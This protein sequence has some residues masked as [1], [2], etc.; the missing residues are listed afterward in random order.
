MDLDRIRGDIHHISFV[1]DIFRAGAQPFVPP[2]AYGIGPA[3]GD[4]L[5]CPHQR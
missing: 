4:D 1:A 3:L 5:Y 2:V